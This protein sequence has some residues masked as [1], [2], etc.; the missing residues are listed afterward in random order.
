MLTILSTL[1]PIF[2][3]NCSRSQQIEILIVDWHAG[4]A[5]TSAGVGAK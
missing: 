2:L 3:S 5:M 4:L 1:R